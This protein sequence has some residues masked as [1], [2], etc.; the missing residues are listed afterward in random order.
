LAVVDFRPA[1]GLLAAF[2]GKRIVIWARG[3]VKNCS[4]LSVHLR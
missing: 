4:A 3:L 1:V 2:G